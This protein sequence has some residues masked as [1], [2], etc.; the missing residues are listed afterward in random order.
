MTLALIIFAITYLMILGQQLPFVRLERPAAAL[1]GAVAMVA[2][3]VVTPLEAYLD[4]IDH[5][6]I[7]L[8]LGMM[9]LTGFLREAGF[10]RWASWSALRAAR[11]PRRLLAGITLLSAVLSAFLVNDTV[12][13]M[14]TPLVVQLADD[15]DLPPLPFLLAVA[16][17]SNAGS[18]ATPT[19]NPQNMLIANLSGI[20]YTDFVSSLGPAA[21]VATSVVLALL[22]LLCRKELRARE[23]G[24]LE[25]PPPPVD[26]VL[27][28]KALLATCGVM[29]GFLLGFD[30]A[31]TALAGAAFMLLVGGRAHGESLRQV[32][33]LLLLFFAGLFVVVYGVGKSGAAQA[34]FDWATPLFAGGSIW[35]ATILSTITAIGSNLFSNVPFV[36]LVGKWIPTL[37]E[38]EMAWKLLS[39]SS[40]LSGNLTILGSVANLIVLDLAG[41]RGQVSFGRFFAYGLPIT[42]C[43][44]A[45]GVAVLL[46]VG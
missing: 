32:N 8:L 26:R 43:S 42:L 37:E 9:I 44:T 24:T 25:I 1:V 31:W 20:S 15:A 13:L 4:A 46:W 19:G 27:L 18:A 16:F 29:I 22:L 3:G 39:L 5:A 7:A 35:Q 10:F 23:L 38:P 40:T 30:L 45:A 11:T 36:L 6:T 34:A 14:I 12:C 21:L 28:G 41:A 33:W 17:G 2:A